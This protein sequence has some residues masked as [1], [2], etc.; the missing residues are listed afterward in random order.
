[1]SNNTSTRRATLIFIAEE[2]FLLSI[3]IAMFV[4][5]NG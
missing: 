3:A 4:L 1:M 5:A 2:V